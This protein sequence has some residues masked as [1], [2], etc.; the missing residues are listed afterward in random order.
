MTAP[1][2]IIQPSANLGAEGHQIH[3]C[4]VC[5]ELF[6]ANCTDANPDDDTLYCSE[7]CQEHVER[8]Q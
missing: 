4:V 7:Q 8:E 1:V 6:C 2:R 3:R 5:E